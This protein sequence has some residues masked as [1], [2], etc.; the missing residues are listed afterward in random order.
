MVSG[1]IWWPFRA[2]TIPAIDLALTAAIGR[3]FWPDIC[4]ALL[5]SA[6]AP[7]MVRRMAVT[8]LVMI[9]RPEVSQIGPRG[10]HLELNCYNLAQF[11]WDKSYLL[12]RWL[13]VTPGSFST[14]LSGL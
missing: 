12:P 2:D 8:S 1:Q 3:Q 5:L 9:G 10:V 11:N 14:L 6:K 4:E 13:I 7:Q